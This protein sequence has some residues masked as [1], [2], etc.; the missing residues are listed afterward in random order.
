MKRW[1]PFVLLVI[2]VT[3]SSHQPAGPPVVNDSEP[4]V[5]FAW[6]HNLHI[7]FWGGDISTETRGVNGLLRFIARKMM[8]FFYF[9]AIALTALY[10]TRH[11]ALAFFITVL[12]ACFDEWHQSF[13]PGRGGMMQDVVLDSA[14]AFTMLVLFALLQRLRRRTT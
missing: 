6:L 4:I 13:I 11:Y 1:I 8:H 2:I 5:Q 14:G 10:A 3:W 9:G 7:T 12:V